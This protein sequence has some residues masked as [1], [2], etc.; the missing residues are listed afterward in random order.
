MQDAPD[1]LGD[2][3]ATFPPEDFLMF[4]CGIHRSNIGCEL[5]QGQLLTSAEPS[6]SC[7]NCLVVISGGRSTVWDVPPNCFSFTG[8]D[9][10]RPWCCP[11]RLAASLT[12]GSQVGNNS[13]TMCLPVFETPFLY[14]EPYFC[15]GLFKLHRQGGS[16][17]HRKA[18]MCVG[19]T[20][21][22]LLLCQLMSLALGF[23]E[24][25]WSRS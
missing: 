24:R 23:Q 20:L 15:S 7:W 12:A 13:F 18:G 11:C 6:Q 3:I 2:I 5:L 8:G 1:S 17:G 9:T 16:T 25:G 21:T 4:I 10:S 14:I 19:V 22:V